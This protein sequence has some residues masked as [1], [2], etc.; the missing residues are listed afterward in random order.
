MQNTKLTFL[1]AALLLIVQPAPA[2]VLPPELSGQPDSSHPLPAPS[3]LKPEGAPLALP[4]VEPLPFEGRKLTAGL[5]MFVKSYRFIG[6]TVISEKELKKVAAPYTG[7]T[8]NAEDIEELRHKITLLYVGKG[9]INS[10]A[11]LPDQEIE[12]QLVTF[13]IVEGQLN[14]INI[15]GAKKLKIAYIKNRLLLGAA[16]PL[17]INSLQQ[18]LLLLQQKGLIEKI[19]AELSPGVQPGTSQL[20]VLVKEAPPYQAGVTFSNHYSPSVG[21]QHLEFYAAHKNLSG[22]G[23]ALEAKYGLTP[24]LHDY[25]LHYALP[26][27]AKD[28]KI[29]IR[30]SQNNSSVIEAPFNQLNITSRSQTI[31]LDL[32]HPVFESPAQSLI[33]RLAFESRQ[34]QTYLLNL[35]FSF[36]SGVPDGKSNESVLR[37]SQEWIK[38][39]AAEALTLRSTLSMGTTNAL[40]KTAGTGPDK[41]FVSW[42]AQGQWAKRLDEK[43]KQFVLL[44]NL[45]WTPH[46]L[47]TLERFGLGGANTVRGYRETQ[48][49]RDNGFVISAEYRI[50]VLFDKLGESRT[51][52]TP[53]IDYGKGW[54]SD[55]AADQPPDIA[56]AGIGMLWNPNKH[57]QAQLDVAHAFRKFPNPGKRDLQDM[58][59]HFSLNYRM[60]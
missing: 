49:L 24:G 20:N 41:S 9:Y 30:I 46:S 34:S 15:S 22:W 47:L 59:I 39:E 14:E 16:S 52:I 26:L 21:A 27:D 54:N 23:D 12:D 42:L 28:N 18:S 53:F 56:S 43:G 45:Q 3:F 13:K 6:N 51:Q 32:E 44:S 11:V 7:K 31:G 10:G 25:S 8:V 5:R 19:N 48:L 37:F 29:G 50:P 1:G 2:Q 55:R 58:G 35:P 33:L 36:S 38:K 40:P 60:Y 17:N 57:W 4:K